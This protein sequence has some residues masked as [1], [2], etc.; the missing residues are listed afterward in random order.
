ME[1]DNSAKTLSKPCWIPVS[2]RLPNGEA[3]RYLVAASL[4]ALGLRVSICCYTDNLEEVDEYDFKDE[5]RGGFYYYD[6]EYGY[7]EMSG[8]QYWMPLPEPP[9][10]GE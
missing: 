3:E 7:C 2:E 5:K 4:R 6:Y 9:K 10:E 1:A 8:V